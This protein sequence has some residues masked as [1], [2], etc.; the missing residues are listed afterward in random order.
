MLKSAYLNREQ[1]GL[2]ATSDRRGGCLCRVLENGAGGKRGFKRGGRKGKS[3]PKQKLGN[4]TS[5]TERLLATSPITDRQMVCLTNNLIFFLT[6]ICVQWG[7]GNLVY[8]EPCVRGKDLDRNPCF[9]VNIMTDDCQYLFGPGTS[10]VHLCY[11]GQPDEITSLAFNTSTS[12]K[13]AHGPNIHWGGGL[14]GE[15]MDSWFNEKPEVLFMTTKTC[16]QLIGRSQVETPVLSVAGIW[17]MK[18]KPWSRMY[19][20]RYPN[21]LDLQLCIS[22]DELLHK[23]KHF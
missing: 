7:R 6:S 10:V 13:M 19:R 18:V 23:R 20:V 8:P 2:V 15:L 12:Q 4:N 1:E 21:N 3:M 22:H 5:I 9:T 17:G 11:W 16:L 14:K